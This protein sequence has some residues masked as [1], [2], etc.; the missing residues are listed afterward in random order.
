M[1]PIV[2]GIVGGIASGKST[3]AAELAVA[4][5]AG[6]LD[7][8][9]VARRVLMRPGI[10]DEVGRALPRAVGKGGRVDRARLAE[11]VFRDAKALARL[12]SILHP[13]I[14]RAL[15]RRLDLAE[16]KVVLVDAPLLQE[17]GLDAMCDL[18]AYVACPARMRRARSRRARGWTSKEHD[19]R[20]ARQWSCR[21]KRAR[22]D[23]VV[24]HGSD[25]RTFRSDMRRLRKRIEALRKR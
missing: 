1:T 5:G 4:C 6:R 17:T 14:R 3:V 9:A 19:A 22:A 20:E 12:E 7:A 16:E 24:R 13:P 11:L 18:V 10:R 23:F 15:Q 8:D 21:K 2:V 25:P